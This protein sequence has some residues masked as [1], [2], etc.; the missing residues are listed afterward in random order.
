MGFLGSLQP[1]V[2]RVC[3]DSDGRCLG[4]SMLALKIWGFY[5]ESLSALLSIVLCYLVKLLKLG[6][7]LC[8]A[9]FSVYNTI[10]FLECYYAV[11][12]AFTM[13]KL[14]V[15]NAVISKNVSSQVGP[16][17]LKLCYG[18]CYAGTSSSCLVLS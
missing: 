8:Q 15:G 11:P 18:C 17:F 4:S 6:A 7:F 10:M 13:R 9:G 2:L 5:L 12:Q 16:L 1:G 14:K 3:R